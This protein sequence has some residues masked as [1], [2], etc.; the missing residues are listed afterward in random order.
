VEDDFAKGVGSCI[1]LVFRASIFLSNVSASSV[2]SPLVD[3]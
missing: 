3:I 1:R 2:L